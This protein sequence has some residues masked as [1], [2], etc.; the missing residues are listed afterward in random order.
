MLE[1][2]QNYIIL[3]TNNHDLAYYI[4]CGV[5]LFLTFGG[6][7]IIGYICGL[8]WQILLMT[9]LISVLRNYTMGFHCH[10]NI[11]CFIVSSVILIIFGII[12]IN[13]SVWAVFLLSIYCS[14]DIYKKA[15]VELN[16]DYKDK[17][18]DWHFTRAVIVILIYLII[19]IIAYYIQMYEL[20]KC[21]LL[22]IVMVDL[23]L[24][25][26]EKLYI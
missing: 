7:F 18:A 14:F 16:T 19:S 22:S 26:N 11:K 10:T 9:V 4:T 23:L 21:I 25:K 5:Y 12:S 3:K 13:I 24:F 1:R 6:L 8:T 20:C 17:N 2:I 15:P